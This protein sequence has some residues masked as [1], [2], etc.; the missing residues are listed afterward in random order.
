M[1]SGTCSSWTL[2][3]ENDVDKFV[4]KDGRRRKQLQDARADI[5]RDPTNLDG[6]KK[7][8]RLRGSRWIAIGE[9]YKYRIPGGDWRL[10]Y[11]VDRVAC[12]VEIL[13]A[14][15]HDDLNVLSALTN[16]RR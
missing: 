12:V 5:E 16:L 6:T 11:R 13:H 9:C 14:G 2:Y 10:I 1:P 4:K 3:I 8:L 15:P 7:K